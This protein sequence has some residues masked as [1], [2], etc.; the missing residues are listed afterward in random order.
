M[1]EC[2]YRT[3][4]PFRR[5]FVRIRSV[6]TLAR[7]GLN[8]FHMGEILHDVCLADGRLLVMLCNDD[9][10]EL[11]PYAR[12]LAVMSLL[13]ER[14]EQTWGWSLKRLA[15]SEGRPFLPDGKESF[16][17]AAHARQA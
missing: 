10:K 3:T 9:C 11:H 2:I 13:H 15:C 5:V 12:R 7:K 6:S 17:F 14:W 4:F 8:V 1:V 16:V